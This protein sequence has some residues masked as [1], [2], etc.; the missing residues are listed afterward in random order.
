MKNISAEC[1]SAKFVELLALQHPILLSFFH[2]GSSATPRCRSIVVSMPW[3]HSTT[4]TMSWCHE[5]NLVALQCQPLDNVALQ[6]HSLI[7]QC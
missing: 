6:C 4:C 3:R 5:I 7:L 1:N 2:S